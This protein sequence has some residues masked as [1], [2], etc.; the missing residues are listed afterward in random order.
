MVN[1]SITIRGTNSR[2]KWVNGVTRLGSQCVKFTPSN[3]A[4]A[5]LCF[6]T[7]ALTKPAWYRAMVTLYREPRFFLFG[8]HL[9][10]LVSVG[11][12]DGSDRLAPNPQFTALVWRDPA[13]H[14]IRQV[15]L[16]SQFL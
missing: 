12:P 11:R 15:N 5:L 7:V 8:L 10:H 3:D 16:L 4:R 13:I 2:S 6:H 9:C 14:L 1:E